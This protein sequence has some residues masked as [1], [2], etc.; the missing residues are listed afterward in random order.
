MGMTFYEM[1]EFFQDLGVKNAINLD[2]GS[3]S[4]LWGL[5]GVINRPS[6]GYERRVFNIAAIVPRKDGKHKSR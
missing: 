5:G 2:G 4:T 6:H 3:S 1:A